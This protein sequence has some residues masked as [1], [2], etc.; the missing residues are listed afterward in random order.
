[1]RI[2]KTPG[3]VILLS[4]TILAAEWA[5]NLHGSVA[6]LAAEHGAQTGAAIEAQTVQYRSGTTS[7]DAFVA[8]PSESGTRL[9]SPAIIVIHDDQG[10]DDSVLETTRLLASEGF[11]SF[12]PDLL[13]RLARTPPPPPTGRGRRPTPVARLSLMQTVQDIRAAFALLSEDST[14]ETERISVIGFG[15]GG[16][17]AFKLAEQ[18]PTL[19]KAVV[20]YG[21]TS[22]DEQLHQIRAPIL[23]HYAEY[24]FPTTAQVLATKR[25]LGSR[26]T[27]HIYPDMDRGFF[28]GG[29]GAIDYVAL[30]RGRTSAAESPSRTEDES[31]DLVTVAVRLAWERTLA[32]LRS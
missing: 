5:L 2:V 26:F 6:V 25:R 1:M 3:I 12:A 24:D 32:F 17:R 13:S 28:G 8:R 27:Y 14:V 20:F 18:T 31:S 29:S 7:L 23:G 16:W 19:H 4:G 15:W 30:I 11:V 22:D 9:R 21:T 10:L